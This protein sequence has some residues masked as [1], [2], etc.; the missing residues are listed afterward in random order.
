[1]ILMACRAV[2][3]DFI[4][5]L[6]YCKNYSMVDSEVKLYSALV[7]EG[8]E[9]EKDR[10]LDAYKEAHQKYRKIR[11]EQFR[12]VTNAVWVSEALCSLGFRTTP[13]HSGVKGALDIFFQD[14]LSTVELC[15]GA[16]QLLSQFASQYRVGLISNFTYAPVIYKCLQKTGIH[17][18]F[19]TVVISEEVEL[20]KPSPKIFYDTLNCLGVQAHEA[21][22][23]GDSP[24]EDIKGAKAAGLRTVFKPSQFN[25][26]EDLV[27]SKQTPDQ[28]VEE[29]AEL[30]QR[31]SQIFAMEPKVES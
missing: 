27:Q 13:E 9:L 18:Y 24:L 20:R 31:I 26:L 12:E 6:V 19:N 29:L 21:V 16:E 11:Y 23:I 22:F 7:S 28:I 10:F 5:T 17:S 14:F 25:S 1:V 4:G 8:F 2:I 15:K 30:P 3:F